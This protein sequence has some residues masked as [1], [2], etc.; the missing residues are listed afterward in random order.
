MS[1][2]YQYENDG[3]NL[4]VEIS[5]GVWYVNIRGIPLY[6]LSVRA[7]QYL[8]YQTRFMSSFI[9]PPHGHIRPSDSMYQIAHK[10]LH[11]GYLL[12]FS[13]KPFGA[14]NDYIYVNAHKKFDILS[15]KCITFPTGYMLPIS[16]EL[17]I[18]RERSRYVWNR[19]RVFKSKLSV[20]HL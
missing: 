12:I 19:F 7:K 11:L 18:V 20:G 8:K 1:L 3:K 5:R 14:G 2:T 9:A 16:L 6:V 13:K 4:L 15:I 10:I 17:C